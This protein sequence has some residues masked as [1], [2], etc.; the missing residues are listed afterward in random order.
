MRLLFNTFEKESYRFVTRSMAAA[1]IDA[2]ETI[3]VQ[4]KYHDSMRT[5]E[6]MI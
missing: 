4:I 6:L 3:Q 2:F 1:V 5:L